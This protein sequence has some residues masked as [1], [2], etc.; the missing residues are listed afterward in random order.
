MRLYSNAF[1]KS[2]GSLYAFSYATDSLYSVIYDPVRDS[3]LC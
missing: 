2:E 1:Q 3:R